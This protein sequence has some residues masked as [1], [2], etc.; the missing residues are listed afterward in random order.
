[1]SCPQGESSVAEA[2]GACRAESVAVVVVALPPS[3]AAPSLPSPLAPHAAS[4]S[5][6]TATAYE[7][8]AL[9]QL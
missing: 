2:V 5:D 4:N 3:S 6:M 9:H 7:R 8:D 1:M